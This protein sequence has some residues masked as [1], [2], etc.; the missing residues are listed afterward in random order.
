MLD[1]INKEKE[2]N[3]KNEKNENE[4]NIVIQETV[5]MEFDDN[6]EE[7]NKDEKENLISSGMNKE[8]EYSDKEG[9]EKE[10]LPEEQE[11]NNIINRKN[12]NENE[13]EEQE[14]IEVEEIVEKKT[15][16]EKNDLPQ[17]TI[18]IRNEIKNEELEYSSDD[19]NEEE[20]LSSEEEEY[21]DKNKE[22]NITSSGDGNKNI[23]KIRYSQRKP[24]KKEI[25]SNLLQKMIDIT[26]KRKN[27]IN[28]KENNQPTIHI[29][30]LNEYM[31]ELEDKLILMKKGYIETL[32]E[33]HFEKNKDNKKE[34]ILKANIPKKRNEV[35][36]IF[37]K[38]MG[39]IK[40]KLELPNQKYYYILILN[41]LKK[42]KNINKDEMTEEIQLY[43][44]Q[45]S[46]RKIKKGGENKVKIKDNYDD[47]NWIIQQNK[48]R[49]MGFY[50]FSIIIPLAYVI[51]F[52]FA[53]N[54]A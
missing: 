13:E 20:E 32:V 9:N 2:E 36:R 45:K 15:S 21:V 26:N 48:K 4:Q 46:I 47:Y 52:V 7:Q 37:K 31:K 38:L 12:I 11:K 39:Y 17:E 35:K 43:K 5:E 29:N 25:Y 23:I 14:E 41:I 42:Y 24:L 18:N 1:R 33:K 10:D 44:K 3:E 50:I 27:R 54:K 28:E 40:D 16:E 34:I 22:P 53:N 30:N 19:E 51:N 6:N 49:G 8:N